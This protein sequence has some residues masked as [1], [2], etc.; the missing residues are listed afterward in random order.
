MQTLVV[1]FCPV[2]CVDEL[3]EATPDSL[4]R[5][6][7]HQQGPMMGRCWAVDGPFQGTGMELLADSV[8]KLESLIASGEWSL[9]YAHTAG[10]WTCGPLSQV[11]HPERAQYWAVQCRDKRGSKPQSFIA[12]DTE[13]LRESVKHLVTEV[14][15]WETA[16]SQP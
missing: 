13:E 7:Q 8:K 16:R 10:H 5:V 1:W 11:R 3:A 4:Q 15:A 12:A 6:L 14:A 9:Q 2:N